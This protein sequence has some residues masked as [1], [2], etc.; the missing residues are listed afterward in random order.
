MNKY[1]TYLLAFLT[2][3][4][5][6]SCGTHPKDK[7]VKKENESSE[8]LQATETKI[9]SFGYRDNLLEELYNEL[10]DKSP[11][12]KKL[13]DDLHA[14]RSK[15]KEVTEEFNVYDA[16]SKNY[17][18]SASSLSNSIE[19]SLLKK[20]IMELVSSSNKAYTKRNA[21]LSSLLTQISNNGGTL[22]DHHS[23][24][25]VI[26]TLPIIERFQKENLPKKG[27]K[28]LLK[29]QQKLIEQTDS[30]TMQ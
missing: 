12:L 25:K 23:A 7:E 15:T 5:I 29:E 8:A 14:M 20:R 21:A 22:N 18:N 16:K 19:D 28:E 24:L 13:E 4:V 1:H 6:L 9:S 3:T 26:V 27:Y 30:I 11:K 17:Y 10:V 2:L